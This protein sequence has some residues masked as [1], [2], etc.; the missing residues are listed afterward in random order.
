M[1]CEKGFTAHKT[2]CSFW[3]LWAF[4][5]TERLSGKLEQDTRTRSPRLQM[6]HVYLYTDIQPTLEAQD[7][8]LFF[9]LCLLTRNIWNWMPFTLWRQLSNS[10][11]FSLRLLNISET[12]MFAIYSFAVVYEHT[13]LCGCCKLRTTLFSL[14]FF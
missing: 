14:F 6:I 11:I 12:T 9:F 3:A 1:L 5:C 8:P 7:T 2:L 4:L 13:L 10:A